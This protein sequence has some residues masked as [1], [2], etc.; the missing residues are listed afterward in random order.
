MADVLQ[1]YVVLGENDIALK[2]LPHF[3]ASA[4][5]GCSDLSV[6][7]EYLPL[8]G[9]PAFAAL[10]KKYDTVSKLPDSAPPAPASP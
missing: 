9:T 8:H 7:P 10:V 3:C 2:L 4:P 6:N 5:A 1:L